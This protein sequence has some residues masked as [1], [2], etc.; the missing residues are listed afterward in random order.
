ME[1]DAEEVSEA[2]YHRRWHWRLASTLEET[3]DSYGLLVGWLF[4]GSVLGAIVLGGGALVVV[5]ILW[6]V[7]LL[8]IGAFALIRKWEERRHRG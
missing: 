3:R 8:W 6:G 1:P 4:A 2:E 7:P 5:A